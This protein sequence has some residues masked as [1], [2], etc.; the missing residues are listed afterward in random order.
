MKLIPL[1]HLSRL[2]LALCAV[3]AFANVHAQNYPSRPV[4]VIVI[5]PP[6]GAGDF[7]ARTAAAA[8]TAAFGQ[9]GVVD[10]RPG[11]GGTIAANAVAKS[12][13]DGYTLLVSDQGATVHAGALFKQLPYDPGKELAMVSWVAST[14]FIVVAGPALKASS[15]R[16]LIDLAKANP[17]TINYGNAGAGTHHHLSMELFKLRAGLDMPPVFYKG[18]AASV[19]DTVGGQVPITVSGLSTTDGLIKA[20]KLRPIAVMS[21]NRFTTHP[22]VPALSEIVPGFEGV[23]MI[24]VW[25]PAG[26]PR[27]ILLALNAAIQKSLV[28]PETIKRLQ[29][30][31][32]EPMPRG[33]DEANQIWQNDLSTWPDL[34]RRLKI[35][36]D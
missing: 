20:G 27:T 32:L 10:N 26:T 24:G 22:D 7:V 29:E 16:E 8:I 33:L 17:G 28:S 30:L 36:L 25:A 5:V 12:A 19:Q 13:A 21:R 11:A 31:G 14:P 34:I 23:S 35:T 6:G 15:L 4:R 18:G 3:F 9:P 1:A 2:A